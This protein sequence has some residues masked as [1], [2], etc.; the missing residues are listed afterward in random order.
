M[1]M[2]WL[3]KFWTVILKSFVTAK[4]K[5]IHL[6][7]KAKKTF[8][9][10]V[11]VDNNSAAPKLYVLFRFAL[12]C[13]FFIFFINLFSIGNS[14]FGE[15]GDF[16]GGVL[17]P[18]LTFIMF[19]GL[20]ITIIIQQKELGESREQFTRSA[21]ALAGQEKTSNRRAFES[22]FFDLLSVF[23]E[24]VRQID[25]VKKDGSKTTSGRDCFSVFYT[26]LS[27]SYKDKVRKHKTTCS[28]ID[29]L[30]WAFDIFMKNNEQNLSHYFRI[31]STIL[32]YSK[33]APDDLD[34]YIEMFKSQ[35]SNRELLLIFYYCVS[36]R[37][38]E[39]TKMVERYGLLSSMQVEY[40]LKNQHIKLLNKQA[41]G[42]N[43]HM[44]PSVRKPPGIK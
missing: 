23:G 19:M 43:R 12:F 28:D 41:Y 17:N 39:L 11:N 22:T 6:D 8:E 15:W 36:D 16:F 31:I 33:R 27:T 13:V 1:D 26:R 29:I 18:I 24:E 3:H 20:L 40:L 44:L 25:L 32:K 14:S 21:D 34:T 30:V 2:G 4:R 37:D 9:T 10:I 5:L 38:P 7:L 35:L 42:K